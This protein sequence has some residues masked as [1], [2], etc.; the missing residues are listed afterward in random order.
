MDDSWAPP[1]PPPAV[2]SR[3][4]ISL[5]MECSLLR[6][7]IL[8]PK[9]PLGLGRSGS[10]EPGAPVGVLVASIIWTSFH[11]TLIASICRLEEKKFAV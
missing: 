10:E 6:L 1:P 7:L 11:S 9:L 4:S 3:V 2:A 8:L 5:A